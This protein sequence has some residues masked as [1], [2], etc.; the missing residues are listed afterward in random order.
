MM[1]FLVLCLSLH[2]IGGAGLSLVFRGD[3]KLRQA[4]D[5]AEQREEGR[6]NPDWR[7]QNSPGYLPCSCSAP[8]KATYLTYSLVCMCDAKR[9]T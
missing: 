5:D 7:G 9:Y 3:G 6:T 2:A 1:L 4:E 8:P